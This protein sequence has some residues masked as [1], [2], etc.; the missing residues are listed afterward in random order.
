MHYSGIHQGIRP[1]MS[2]MLL[3]ASAAHYLCICGVCFDTE[4]FLGKWILVILVHT[5]QKPQN[6]L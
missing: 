6:R 1:F 2:R 5:V 4:R 3:E